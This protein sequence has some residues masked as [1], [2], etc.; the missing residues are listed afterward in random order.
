ML[1]NHSGKNDRAGCVIHFINHCNV[2]ILMKTKSALFNFPENSDGRVLKNYK[3]GFP[4][5]PENTLIDISILV[6]D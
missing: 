6:V 2:R 4:L 1:Q 5:F 3:A